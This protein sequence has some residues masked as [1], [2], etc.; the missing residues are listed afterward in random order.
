MPEKPEV[1]TVTKK[2]EKRLL[3]RK[4]TDCLVGN[5]VRQKQETINYAVI[6]GQRL[7]HGMTAF[8]RS[9]QRPR[10]VSIQ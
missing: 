1:I 2:L 6:P 10:L 7:G 4:I 5:A 9:Q 8:F 3:G